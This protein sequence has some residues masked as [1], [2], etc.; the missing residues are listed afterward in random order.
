MVNDHLSD[1]ISRIRNG[2]GAFQPEVEAPLNRL[3][4]AVASV[5]AESGF[6]EKVEEKEKV[7]IITLKYKNKKPAITGIRRVSKPGG[8]IY[9][10]VAEL[11]RVLGGLGINILSTPKGVVSEKQAK[12]LRV[13]GEVLAQVW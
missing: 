3:N 12:K 10:G 7:L 2:Y 13:G 9:K 6:A 11:P 4:K 8:R 5:L 1:L